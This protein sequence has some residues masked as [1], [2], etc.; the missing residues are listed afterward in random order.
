[1]CKKSESTALI[2]GEKIMNIPPIKNALE[3]IT[4]ACE[5]KLS[6][7]YPAGIPAKIRTRYEQEL[8]FLKIS[9]HTDDFEI[10]RLL[11]E[12]AAKSS[13]IMTARGT[14]MGSFLYYL[15]GTNCFNPLPVYYYCPQCGHY[16]PIQTHLFGIDLPEK[17]CPNCNASIYADGFNLSI[18]SVWGLD[19][20]KLISFDYN[21]CSE[22]L[23]FAKRILTTL[24]P[25][26]VVAPWGLFE[27][28][29]V[30]NSPYPDQRAIGVNLVG[31]AIL[32]TGNHIDDYSD[33]VSYLEDGD[34]CLTGGGWELEQSHIKPIRLFTMPLIENLI[35]LQRATGVY[36]NELPPNTLRDI[37]WSNIYNSTILCQHTSMLFHEFKPKN[38]RD[39]V[40]LEASSHNTTTWPKDVESRIS[41]FDFK[42]MISTESFQK[43]PCFTR[44][45]F[46]D[47]L[48]ETGVD[49]ETA[50]V[51]SEMIRKGRASE[52]V[53]ASLKEK[54][55]ALNI[56]EEIREVAKYYLYLFPRA[57]CIEYAL[58]Y[59]RLAYYAKLDSRAFSKIIFKKKG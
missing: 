2:K 8:S 34:T 58:I 29:S 54:F 35:K 56:P 10:Y 19:G 37:T 39:M 47:Y 44:E 18:E 43:Y 12:E 22:F 59:A 46:F 1:M 32:P 33:F 15:L 4:E 55:E 26:N 57:H 40:A 7:L 3:N 20:K 30:T 24:Y 5:R 25:N 16:E 53:K 21:V 51:A 31:Y 23:P 28:D 11:S 42:Q 50:F 41:L 9:G 14:L 13:Y 48:I 36:A 45:D 52:K 17:K 27:L 6:H 49:R 38:F